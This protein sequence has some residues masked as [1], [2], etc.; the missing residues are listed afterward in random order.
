MPGLRKDCFQVSRLET[1]STLSESTFT[2]LTTTGASRGIDSPDGAEAGG[3]CR[4]AW[5]IRSSAL[6]V[7]AFLG[8]T[9]CCVRSEPEAAAACGGDPDTFSRRDSFQRRRTLT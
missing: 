2:W 6:S 9:V 5:S 3:F 1:S 7:V 4:A 8:G